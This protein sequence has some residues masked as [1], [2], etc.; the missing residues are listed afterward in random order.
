MPEYSTTFA[1]T[2]TSKLIFIVSVVVCLFWLVGQVMNVYHF[3]VVGAIF[4]ILW[5]PMVVMTFLLPIMAVIF[6][7]KEKFSLRSLYLYSFLIVAATV[8]ILVLR[9]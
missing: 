5:F 1:N 3:T 7:I 8:L 2:N 9:K 4:E 6:L